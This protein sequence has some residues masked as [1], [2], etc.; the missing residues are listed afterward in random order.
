MIT[1]L[2]PFFHLLLDN[3]TVDLPTGNHPLLVHS[4]LIR[5]ELMIYVQK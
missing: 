1:K 2:N 4:F 5:L 3:H